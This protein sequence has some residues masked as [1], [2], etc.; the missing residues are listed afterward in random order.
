MSDLQEWYASRV[1]EPILASLEEF[2]ERDS[3]WTLSRILNLTLNEQIWT[4]RCMR[5]VTLNYRE[6]LR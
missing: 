2:Q 3:G 1:I 5:V 6:K 4:I